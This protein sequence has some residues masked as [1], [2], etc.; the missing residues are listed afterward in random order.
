MM[1]VCREKF[2]KMY[3]YGQNVRGF[4]NVVAL[5]FVGCPVKAKNNNVDILCEV[6]HKTAL[7]MDSIRG[8]SSI[9]CGFKLT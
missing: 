6:V 5:Q 8:Q 4:P 9:G 7:N 3:S 1:N 2:N